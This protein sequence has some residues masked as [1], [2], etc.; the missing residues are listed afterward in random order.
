[1]VDSIHPCLLKIGLDTENVC[2]LYKKV[3]QNQ[4]LSISNIT[5]IPKAQP[6]R[7]RQRQQDRVWRRQSLAGLVVDTDLSVAQWERH[8]PVSVIL[9]HRHMHTGIPVTS[10]RNT[11]VVIALNK[12]NQKVMS[13]TI[14]YF[15]YT[16]YILTESTD[17][18]EHL[19]HSCFTITSNH[20]N[21]IY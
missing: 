2:S 8:E 1:M 10:Y 15:V 21:L 5:D 7:W 12:R 13:F 4:A 9:L 20:F 17:R 19:S 11:Q 6:D 3:K 16:V 14:I 18:T